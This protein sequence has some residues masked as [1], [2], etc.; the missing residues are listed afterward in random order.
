VWQYVFPFRRVEQWEAGLYYVL[1][2]YWRTVGPGCWPL[3]PYFMDVVPVSMVPS[4]HGTAL[5]TITLRDGLTLTYSATATVQ[6]ENAATAT[7]AV[8]KWP[9]TTMELIAGLLSERLADVDPKRFDP[10]R[11]KRDRLLE[12]L[13]EEIDTATKVFGVRVRS[14]RF[15]NFALG[16][17]TY[18]LMSERA[19]LKD[20]T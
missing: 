8:D 15:N 18:R 12:E 16:V 6:V 1:G 2:R 11:N 3:T 7:N 19:T 20:V 14:L 10:A 5:Q 13:R 4:I 17:R 9:E